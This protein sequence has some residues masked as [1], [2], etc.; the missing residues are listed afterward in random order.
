NATT[1]FLFALPRLIFLIIPLTYLLFGMVNIYGYSLSI[2][3]YA[4]PHIVLSNLTNSRVQGRFRFSFWNEVYEAVLA[5]YILFPTLL[6]LIN[7]RLGKFNVT[8]KGGVIRRSYFDRRIALPFLLLLALNVAGLYK[9]ER[10][11][12]MDPAHHDTVIMNSVWA[13]YN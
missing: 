13:I 12:V 3:A 7:P 8:S 11:Y 9:A 6:A 2:F 10:R 1:H 4:L 5:P